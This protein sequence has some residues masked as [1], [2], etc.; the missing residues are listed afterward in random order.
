[1][2]RRQAEY[3]RSLTLFRHPVACLLLFGKYTGSAT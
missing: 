3:R 2:A 1:M